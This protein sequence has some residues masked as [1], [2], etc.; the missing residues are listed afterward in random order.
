MNRITKNLLDL[1]KRLRED[2]I[3]INYEQL[4]ENFVFSF[5]IKHCWLVEVC[6]ANGDWVANGGNISC[7]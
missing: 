3:P 6:M 5:N 7:G 1:T 2:A 4:W